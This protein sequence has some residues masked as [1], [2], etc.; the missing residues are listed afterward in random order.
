VP[1]FPTISQR[2]VLVAWTDS[3]TV[4]N[5]AYGP[6]EPDLGACLS[7]G[8]LIAETDDAILL[9]ASALA[10]G[11]FSERTSIPRVNV[12]WIRPLLCE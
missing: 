4:S 5:W 11:A 1:D 7:V 3:A 9:G 6:F 8:W 12:V 2:L 10:E